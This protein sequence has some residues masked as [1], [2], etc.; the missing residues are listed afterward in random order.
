MSH[1]GK[2]HRKD[3]EKCKDESEGASRLISGDIPP[4]VLRSSQGGKV[5]RKSPPPGAKTR[6]NPPDDWTPRQRRPSS[7][8]WVKS[9][10]KNGPTRGGTK[11]V[12]AA[13]QDATYQADGLKDALREQSEETR[14]AREANMHL[15]RDFMEAKISLADA[16]RKLGLHRK[17]I[18][19]RHADKIKNFHCSWQDETDRT[20]WRFIGLCCLIPCMFLSLCIYLQL[21]EELICW[22]FVAA[23]LTYQVAAVF[24][25]RY[26]CAKRGLRTIFSKRTTH[27]FDA[28]TQ[29]DWDALDRR[30]DVMSMRKLLHDDARYSVIA[31]RKSLNGVLL[32][33]DK[34]GEHTGAPSYSMISHEL[35]AQLTVPTVMYAD[36]AEVVKGRLAIAAKT[37]HTVNI[38]CY[39]YQESEDVARNTAKVALGLWYQS[40]QRNFAGS[41]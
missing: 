27:S 36:D 20:Y 19:Q 28:L 41:F 39:L 40:S 21:I 17:R 6:N 16:E 11:A 29:E 30:A 7:K 37:T 26:L 25:D 10:G 9:G 38:D 31:Y 34:F 32:N 5:G 14:V 2:W 13:A 8:G 15:H 18:D 35:L 22:Q 4:A 3:K 24:L 23:G 12:A 1:S 33:V